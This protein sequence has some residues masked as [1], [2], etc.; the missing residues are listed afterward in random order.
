[1]ASLTAREIFER[2]MSLP[3]DEVNLPVCEALLGLPDRLFKPIYEMLLRGELSFGDF[4]P[5]LSDGGRRPSVKGISAADAWIRKSAGRPFAA[6]TPAQPAQE[7]VV[8]ARNARFPEDARPASVAK[9]A[10]MVYAEPEP[11]IVDPK[12]PVGRSGK[13]RQ[14]KDAD[15][16]GL[17]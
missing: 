4:A 12:A 13:L 7:A 6:E 14:L 2:S 3:V 15:R 11:F 8:K 16:L 10:R 17:L 9:I 1:M 5:H